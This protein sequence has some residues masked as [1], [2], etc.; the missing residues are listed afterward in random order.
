MIRVA[1][2]VVSSWLDFLWYLNRQKWSWLLVVGG[3]VILI[4]G[5]LATS[6]LSYLVVNQFLVPRMH[7]EWDVVLAP[8]V[9]SA[10]RYATVSIAELSRATHYVFELMLRVPE[11]R[12][13]LNGEKAVGLVFES[14]NGTVL[15]S[16]RRSVSLRF[17][18]WLRLTIER[19]FWAVPMVWGLVDEAQVI[20]SELCGSWLHRSDAVT[21]R[22]EL[23]STLQVYSAK[24]TAKASLEG[25][26]YYWY[27]FRL[28]TMTV[29]I[30]AVWAIQSAVI[31]CVAVVLLSKANWFR[32]EPVARAT[33]RGERQKE[34]AV[35]ASEIAAKSTH[36][37]DVTESEEFLASSD[38]VI[39]TAA[40][41]TAQAKVH[42]RKLKKKHQ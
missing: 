14:W 19:I 40:M 3:L 7:R 9:S 33:H 37:D 20:T 16:Q 15:W 18:S 24:L 25:I 21:A 23:D 13:N 38:S 30:L 32:D 28:T 35:E 2:R 34:V 27:Y 11:S 6:C 5:A 4:L 41:L 26:V 22:I 42:R 29:F 10:L 31:L 36:S 12:A 1:R 17:K 39:P 8:P